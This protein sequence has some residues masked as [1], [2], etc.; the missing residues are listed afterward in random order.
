[1]NNNPF[2]ETSN[3][4]R[5]LALIFLVLMGALL[6]M[7]AGL[8]LQQ[9]FGATGQES[10]K[11]MRIMQLSTQMGLF[12]LPPLAWAWTFGKEARFALGIGNKPGYLF[13]LSGILL[14]IA[15]LPLIHQLA[16]WN[17]A[18]RLPERLAALESALRM[19]EDRAEALTNMFLSVSTIHDLL[20]NLFMIA[21]VPA[22]GEE[23]LFRGVIQQQLIRSFRNVHI[24]VIFGAMLFS[25]LHFQFYGLIPRFVLGVFLG[26]FFLW[27]RSLWV[28]VAMHLVNNAMAVVAYYLH[29]NGYT[30]IPME[31]LG[32]TS[33][34]WIVA[35]SALLSFGFLIAAKHFASPDQKVMN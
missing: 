18:I 1:M 3:A 16:E 21:F 9:L 13:L 34:W 30:S 28:P 17:N 29:H 5:W 22:L 27:S 2:A 15:A 25:A 19:L 14:M 12:F 26:Y 32:G 35:L 8:G 6:G 20:F 23:L 31:E 33:D 24:A 4:F 10:L 11:A 7:L